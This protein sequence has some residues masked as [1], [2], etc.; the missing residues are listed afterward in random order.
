M[1]TPDTFDPNG[2]FKLRLA[3]TGHRPEKLGGYDSFAQT[4]LYH[5]AKRTLEPL[6]GEIHVCYSGMALGWDQAIALACADLKIPFIA[7]VPFRG[8]EC[9]WPR[10]SQL[11][12][13]HLMSRAQTIVYVCEDGYAAWKMQKRNE[14]MV[15]HSN[16]LMALWDGSTDGTANCVRYAERVGRQTVNLWDQWSRIC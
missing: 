6:A 7:A 13:N 5:F 16:R 14:W 12:Y 4:K 15:D 3:F 9:K 11:I 10:E 8:Q 2:L 1:L